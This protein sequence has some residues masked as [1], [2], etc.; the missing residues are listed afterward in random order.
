METWHGWVYI[1]Y[2]RNTWG[3]EDLCKD[4]VTLKPYRYKFERGQVLRVVSQETRW[5]F[6]QWVHTKVWAL[7]GTY[8]RLIEP[9][10]FILYYL[11]L[12]ELWDFGFP[13]CTIF[14][15]SL[16]F[17]YLILSSVIIRTHLPM[18]TFGHSYSC[19][20]NT[21]NAHVREGTNTLVRWIWQSG[22]AF[23]IYYLPW[24]LIVIPTLKAK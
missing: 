13:L 21:H 4:E 22:W 3:W 15:Y 10:T 5:R 2:S 20:Y 9:H 23:N 6:Y 7:K 12:E 18:L 24:G 14:Q 8:L 17:H 11:S 1:I 16:F 19:P